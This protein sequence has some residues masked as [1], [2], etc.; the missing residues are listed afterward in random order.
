MTD[1]PVDLTHLQEK[2]RPHAMLPDAERI[3]I[4]KVGYRVKYRRA[5]EVLTHMEDLLSHPRID[6]MPHLLLV[7]D[8]NN[9][10]SAILSQFCADHPADPNP[11]GDAAIVPVIKIAASGPDIGDLCTRIL[12]QIN[13]PY[14]EKATPSERIRTTKKIL[15]QTQTK[16]LLIDEIQHMTAGGA[17]KQREFRNGIKDLGNELRMSIVAAGVE[18]AFTVFTTDP[19]LSNRFHPEYLPNWGLTQETGKLLA[20]FARRLPLRK[21]SELTSPEILQKIVWMSEGLLG[22]IYAVLEIAAITSINSGQEQITLDTLDKIQWVN[23]SNRRNR[24]KYA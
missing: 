24:P 8:S 9:G 13:A 12:D 14:R 3:Q 15:A 11:D 1:Y 10:K 6:R 2:A 4:I 16:M 5:V 21:P 20:S 18:E 7:G 23:P 22:E 19:Q 17:V